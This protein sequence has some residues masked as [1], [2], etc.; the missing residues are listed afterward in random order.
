M[1]GTT[2]GCGLRA[3]KAPAS[4]SA[5]ITA[6]IH[7]TRAK[8]TAPISSPLPRL[9][10]AA[11][12]TPTMPVVATTAPGTVTR[13]APGSATAPTNR[14]PPSTSA[15]LSPVAG[16][17]P[18]KPNTANTTA[19]PA[20]ASASPRTDLPGATGASLGTSIGSCGRCVMWVS[21]HL[22]G[23]NAN[24]HVR[25]AEKPPLRN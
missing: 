24:P 23:W 1:A 5:V 6:A 7:V 12:N 8:A 20:D 13:P 15:P 16:A 2:A 14:P 25:H 21:L 3:P 17:A 19:A 9:V 22:A 18:R 4:S 10:V 11:C